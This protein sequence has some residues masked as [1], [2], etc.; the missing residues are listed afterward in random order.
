MKMWIAMVLLSIAGTACREGIGE[1]C[2]VDADCE[3]GLV[4]NQAQHICAKPGTSG[5]IDAEVPDAGIDAR[6]TDAAI[7]AT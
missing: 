5:G 3:S 7:D 1:R 6:P 4:C 2:Q